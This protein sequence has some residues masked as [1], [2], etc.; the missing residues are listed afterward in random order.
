MGTI[1]HTALG[2]TELGDFKSP[3]PLRLQVECVPAFKQL[4][5]LILGKPHHC[6][7]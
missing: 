1:Q 2:S 6:H 4:Y 7:L 5:L 3:Y